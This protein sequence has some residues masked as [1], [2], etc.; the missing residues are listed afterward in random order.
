MQ[1]D[2]VEVLFSALSPLNALIPQPVNR[3]VSQLGNFAPGAEIRGW[4]RHE[5]SQWQF[6]MTRTFAN[7][8]GSDQIAV[9]G[10]FGGTK[11]WDL[12]P[13]SVLRYNGDGTDTGGGPDFRPPAKGAI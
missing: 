8:I 7:V 9:V 3:F 10:E 6:T 4:E 5:V 13:H 1:I 11:V 12:P 2:D